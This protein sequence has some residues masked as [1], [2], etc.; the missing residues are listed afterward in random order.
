MANNNKPI[1]VS[2]KQLLA[3]KTFF[4]NYTEDMLY[5]GAAR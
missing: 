1:F 2:E 5:G 3:I 4:N